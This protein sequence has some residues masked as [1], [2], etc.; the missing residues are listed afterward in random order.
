MLSETLVGSEDTSSSPR[1]AV[2]RAVA[3]NVARFRP[4]AECCLLLVETEGQAADTPP[5]NGYFP[6]GSVYFQYID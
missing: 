4:W 3:A 2:L 1:W 6:L 5:S